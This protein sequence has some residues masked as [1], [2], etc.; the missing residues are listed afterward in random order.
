M[1]YL[2][3]ELWQQLSQ[4]VGAKSI[5]LDKFP[6]YGEE[7]LRLEY[8]MRFQLVQEVIAALRTIRS[9]MKLDPKKKV[10]AESFVWDGITRD[11]IR[12]SHDG[13]VRL[14]MLSQLTISAEP[15]VQAGGMPRSTGQFD[16][17]IAYSDSADTVPEKTR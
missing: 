15:L 16:V 5:A 8:L 11:G 1:R 10:A 6:E 3:E 2:T 14:G 7:Q 4:K 13:I 12:E 9:E 17:R